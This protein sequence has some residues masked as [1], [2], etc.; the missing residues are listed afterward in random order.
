MDDI[1]DLFLGVME[2]QEAMNHKLAMKQRGVNLEFKTNGKTCTTGCKVTVEL[3]G[4]EG[5]SPLIQEHF[6]ADYLKHVRGHEPN[7]EALSAVFDPTA[8]EVTCQ[9]CGTKFSPKNQECPDCG[10]MY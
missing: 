6:K 4:K 8:D 2:L 9:A 10:L 7:F 3:W 1:F 5:D